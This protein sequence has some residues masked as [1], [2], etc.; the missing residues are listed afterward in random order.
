M[1][2]APGQARSICKVLVLVLGNP[3][4][5]DDAV[6]ELIAKE[7]AGRLPADV[8]VMVCRGDILGTMEAWSGFDGLV[9]VD[10]A[11]PLGDPGRIHR[12][13]LCMSALPADASLTSSHAFGLAEAIE[14]ARRLQLA[15]PR[16]IVY[17]IEGHSFHSGAPL[18]PAVAAA[19]RGAA[20][21]IVADIERLRA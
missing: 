10:A 18:T 19:A 1:T 11:A 9:C 12:V 8:P 21:H 20:D 14:L 16:I 15:P 7:L 17:A 5:G 2:D 3:D 4:R 13:D 6:G